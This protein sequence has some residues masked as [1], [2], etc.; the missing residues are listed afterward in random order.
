MSIRFLPIS[1]LVIL[2][3][4]Q[5]IYNMLYPLKNGLPLCM[6]LLVWYFHVILLILNIYK[7]FILNIPLHTQESSRSEWHEVEQSQ[8]THF[9]A[10]WR[11]IAT[12]CCTGCRARGLPSAFAQSGS[13][14]V[15][16]KSVHR[17]CQGSNRGGL[18][19]KSL[20]SANWATDALLPRFN[21]Y[22]FSQCVINYNSQHKLRILFWYFLFNNFP[23]SLRL[24]ISKAIEAPLCFAIH[25]IKHNCVQYSCHQ[26]CT[27]TKGIL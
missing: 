19:R 16:K 1:F 26:P 3:D 4:S 12:F 18:L 24:L 8:H 7:Q 23:P 22:V 15:C 20:Q 10:S 11:T 5:V 13:T 6:H 14:L 17:H 27:N 2:N 25:K 21:T 9:T